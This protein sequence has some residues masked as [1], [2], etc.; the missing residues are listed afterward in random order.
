M[1]EMGLEYRYVAKYL[2]GEVELDEM[3]ELIE[4]KSRQYAKRQKT[5]LKRHDDIVWVKPKNLEEI[6]RLTEEFLSK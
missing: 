2:K 5:W 4:T 6:F 3:K 1:D